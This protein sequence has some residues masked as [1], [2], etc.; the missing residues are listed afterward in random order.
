MGAG[1]DP[2]IVGCFADMTIRSFIA[3]L[4][5][6][7]TH[8]PVPRLGEAGG[9][10][11]TA[12]PGRIRDVTTDGRQGEGLGPFAVKRHHAVTFMPSCAT[13]HGIWS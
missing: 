7:L 3:R 10:E 8:P 5:C 2:A 12:V 6:A 4:A 9:T 1:L 11:T 13:A